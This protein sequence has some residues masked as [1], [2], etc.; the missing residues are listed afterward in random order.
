MSESREYSESERYRIILTENE[1]LLATN[2]RYKEFLELIKDKAPWCECMDASGLAEEALKETCSSH[3]VEVTEAAER[4][5]ALVEERDNLKES[6]KHYRGFDR[7]WQVMYKELQERMASLYEQNAK[8]CDE[9]NAYV[10]KVR[11][12]TILKNHLVLALSECAQIFR[13]C[14]G[15]TRDV[16]T[17]HLKK[18][19]GIAHDAIK[20]NQKNE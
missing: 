20:E 11:D 15:P 13:Y 14:Y 17:T 19:E 7:M 10:M 12:L 18:G 9:H 16:K 2:A 4:L 5:T 8:L 6:V 1:K 3:G